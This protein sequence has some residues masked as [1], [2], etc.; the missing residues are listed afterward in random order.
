M[1]S[2]CVLPAPISMIKKILVAKLQGLNRPYR[3]IK[4]QLYL[5]HNKRTVSY[6]H[7]TTKDSLLPETVW[8]HGNEI[9]GLND[10]AGQLVALDKDKQVSLLPWIKISGSA[11]CLK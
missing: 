11:C 1:L 3:R 2:G 7:Q 8:V 10:R 6:L 4:K 5:H 9:A